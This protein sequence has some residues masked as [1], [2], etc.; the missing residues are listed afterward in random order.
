VAAV[1][2]EV[3]LRGILHPHITLVYQHLH[4][5]VQA[6]AREKSSFAASE[7]REATT[8]VQF[9]ASFGTTQ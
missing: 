8:K 3:H 5:Q 7:F 4:Q 1:S 9:H 2:G 6:H